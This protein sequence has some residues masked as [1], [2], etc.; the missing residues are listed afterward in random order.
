MRWRIAL[1]S[2]FAS[3]S[4]LAYITPQFRADNAV[5]LYEFGETTTTVVKDSASAKFGAPLDLAIPARAAINRTPG[6]LEFLDA[7][8]IRSSAPATK[9]YDACLKTNELS[10]EVTLENAE[11]VEKR[12]G[13]D[14]KKVLQPMRILSYSSGLF[15]R[16]FLVGQSYDMGNLYSA[17]V[18]NS[19]DTGNSLKEP[20]ESSTTAIL[21]PSASDS[22]R[23]TQTVIFTYKAN[24]AKMYLT[25]KDGN[26]FLHK[27]PTAVNFSGSF[28]N[29]DRNAYFVLGNDLVSD[30]KFFSYGS[31]YQTCDPL[32]DSICGNNPNR[33]WRGKLMRVA[34]YCKQLSDTDIF[35]SDQLQVVTN[36][37]LPVSL[38][39]QVT[40]ELTRAQEI[41]NRITGVKTPL[42]N[43]VLDTMAAKIRAKDSI[44]AAALATQDPNFY[45]ITVRDW[46]AKMSNRDET[47]N[48]A[49]N[50]FTATIIGAVRDNLDFR[51]LLYDDIVYKADPTKAS[52]PNN[53]ELDIIKSNNHYE[54]LSNQRFDL[55]KVLMPTTQVLWDGKKVVPMPIPAGLLTTRQWLAA[56]TVAGTNRRAVEYTFR[57]FLCSP[58][59]SVADANGPDDVV[60][61]DIDRF[62]GGSHAKY[63]TTCRACHTIMDGFRPAYGYITFSNNMVKHGFVSPAVTSDAE[64]SSSAGMWQNP[65]FIAQKMNHNESVF[66]EGRITSDDKWVNN[67][68]NGANE[69]VFGWSATKS[70]KGIKEF[71]KLVASSKQFPLCMAQRVF[72]TVCKREPI[73]ADN[74]MIT[75]AVKQF[76]TTKSYSLRYLFER[77]V[78]SK[79]CLGGSFE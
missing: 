46:A 25:D 29:W 27:G 37:V 73:D 24:S 68:V 20:L 77:I 52:V 67:A 33:F 35:G 18:T 32:K 8:Q 26:L 11:T 57:E 60:G 23:R 50:D 34:V 41:F 22:T 48:V 17:T 64:E 74:A 38:S 5:V 53:I 71:G 13:I 63:T 58:I 43:P 12:I 59:S 79:E 44:G 56:H 14:D 76:T 7:T 28:S 72:K 55:S 40:P 51:R 49:L 39:L 47:I 21:A 75:D 36:P 3:S 62:P 78:S 6:T 66:P 1:A 69:A 4:G 2:F 42:F 65:P 9:I 15:N 54:A 45:N 16:N 10:I 70:G 19:G 61:R 31:E 30:S